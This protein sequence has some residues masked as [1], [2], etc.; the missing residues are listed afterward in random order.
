MFW[1]ICTYLLPTTFIFSLSSFCAKFKCKK[2]T[3]NFFLL[4]PSIYSAFNFFCWFSFCFVNKETS[5]CMLTLVQCPNRPSPFSINLV[6]KIYFF[7]LKY[8][9][10]KYNCCFSK[11]SFWERSYLLKLSK[12]LSISR[13]SKAIVI[14]L[15]LS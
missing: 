8:K 9:N 1:F 4:F 11:L 10:I 6:F 2:F 5:F 3:G 7:V 12:I 13:N 15:D 14:S